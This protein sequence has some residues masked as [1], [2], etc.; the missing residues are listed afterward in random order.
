VADRAHGLALVEERAHE[1]DGVL[2]GPQ[3]VGVRHAA[4]QHET[5]VADASASATVPWAVNVSALSSG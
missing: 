5:V 3:E 1:R 2:V 4:R